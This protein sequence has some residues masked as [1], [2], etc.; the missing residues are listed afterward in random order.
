[1]FVLHQQVS[2]LLLLLLLL[3]MLLC[4]QVLLVVRIRTDSPSLHLGNQI[5]V[6]RGVCLSLLRFFV[7]L[8][9]LSLNLCLVSSE[10]VDWTE[11]YPCNVTWC[12][13]GYDPDNMTVCVGPISRDF[14]RNSSWARECARRWIR[15]LSS[16]LPV[17]S[18]CLRLQEMANEAEARGCF[19]VLAAYVDSME[20]W[21]QNQLLK[22]T[23]L[24]RARSSC[25]GE[26][27]L[28]QSSIEWERQRLVSVYS[29]RE[30]RNSFRT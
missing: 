8:L 27:G 23:Q 25:G 2:L 14:I 12:P 6:L 26:C 15:M 24:Q 16:G 28:L 29:G 30:L 17:A 19:S 21:L 20:A 4:Q 11:T 7:D 18:S 22:I 13:D 9:R 3:S 1:M 10:C 5:F